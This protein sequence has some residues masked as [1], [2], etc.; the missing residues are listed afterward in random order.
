[1]VFCPIV[2]VLDSWHGSAEHLTSQ[3]QVFS[4][5][6]FGDSPCKELFFLWFLPLWLRHHSLRKLVCLAAAKK[7]PMTAAN[8][9]PA[10]S[11]PTDAAH[12]SQAAAPHPLQL[13]ALP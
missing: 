6:A 12:L 4:F 5:D 3:A 13:A 11:Q 9:L 10:A 1:M 7:S 2:K 8:P